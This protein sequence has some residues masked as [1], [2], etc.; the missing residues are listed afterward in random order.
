MERKRVFFFK[1]FWSQARLIES[2]KL[3]VIGDGGL[4]LMT[5]G[6]GVEKRHY[7]KVKFKSFK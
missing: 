4:D 3:V 7:L 2:S 5:I 6:K 1:K